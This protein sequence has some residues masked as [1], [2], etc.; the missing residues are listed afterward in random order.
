MIYFFY[1]FILVIFIEIKLMQISTD[2][3]HYKVVT[4]P[5]NDNK[6][7]RRQSKP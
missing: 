2:R 5:S 3:I 4:D 7:S 6:T 1:K